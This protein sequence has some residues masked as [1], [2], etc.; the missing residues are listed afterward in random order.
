MKELQT[1]YSSGFT[2]KNFKAH[3]MLHTVRRAIHF[4]HEN[5]IWNNL[6]QKAMSQD[7]SWLQSAKKYNGI[8]ENLLADSAIE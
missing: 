8:Y 1:G 2:F 3:D 4:Y 5:G 7:Y 6:V